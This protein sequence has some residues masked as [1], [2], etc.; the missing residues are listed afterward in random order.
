MGQ[1][2]FRPGGYRHRSPVGLAWPG[3]VALLLVLLFLI[4][5]LGAPLWGAPLMGGLT[6]LYVAGWTRWRSARYIARLKREWIEAQSGR[7]AL[8]LSTDR[9][10][11]QR[12][13]VTVEYG[14]TLLA[15][16]RAWDCTAVE[17]AQFNDIDRP[18]RL[19]VGMVLRRPSP[20]WLR[21]AREGTVL[22]IVARATRAV[23]ACPN[24]HL[25]LH[26]I[27]DHDGMR[28]RRECVVCDPPMRWIETNN[29]TE[30]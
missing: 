4:L 18:G 24:G 15:V 16:A 5:A 13:Q 10:L 9:H 14:D 21:V 19:E 3:T 30:D 11:A 6:M 27:V 20:H 28:V 29:T 7:P 8:P 12:N 17:L 22:P 2:P 25:E 1:R 26:Q 23:C